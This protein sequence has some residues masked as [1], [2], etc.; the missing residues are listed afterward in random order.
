MSPG[1]SDKAG[2]ATEAAGGGKGVLQKIEDE[3]PE[4]QAGR[5]SV[6]EPIESS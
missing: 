6:N 2:P 1:F 3:R 5:I 4:N